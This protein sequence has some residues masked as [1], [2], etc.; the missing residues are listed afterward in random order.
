LPIYTPSAQALLIQLQAATNMSEL[1]VN[2]SSNLLNAVNDGYDTVAALIDPIIGS[3]SSLA[4]YQA[5]EANGTLENQRGILNF[6][7]NFTITDDPG[8]NRTNIDVSSSSLISSVSTPLV[9]T[10]GNLSIPQSS[11]SVDGYLSHTDWTTFNSKGSGTVTSVATDSTLTGGTITSTGTLGLNIA[12]SNTWTATQNFQNILPALGTTYQVGS[13]SLVFTDGYFTNTRTSNVISTSVL[14]L[15][16]YNA[17]TGSYL[18]INNGATTLF[19]FSV[20]TGSTRNLL[21]D[22]TSNTTVITGGQALN[23][24]SDNTFGSSQIDIATAAITAIT[25]AFSANTQTGATINTTAADNTSSTALT[26]KSSNTW[27]TG[28]KYLNIIDNSTSVFFID[29]YGLP[30][31]DGYKIDPRGATSGNSLIYNGTAFIPQNAGSVISS[32]SNLDGTLTVSPTTG[33][34]VASLALGHSNTWSADQTYHN[35]LSATANTFNIGTATNAF[36]DGYFNIVSGNSSGSSLS[37]YDSPTINSS[38]TLSSG[39]I[40]ATSSGLVELQGT[41]TSITS[42]SANNTSTTA[43]SI[44]STATW[45]T[46]NKYLNIINNAT[47]IF[48]IDAYGIP[49]IDGYKIDPRGSTIGETLIYNGTAYIPSAPTGATSVSSDGT[50]TISPTTGAVIAGLK[51]INGSSVL[52]SFGNGTI[53]IDAYGRAT[54]VNSATNIITGTI[55]T[56]QIAVG[57]GTNTISGTSGLTYTA[58]TGLLAASGTSNSAFFIEG[59]GTA[60]VIIEDSGGGNSGLTLTSTGAALQYFNTP[61]SNIILNSSGASVTGVAL[62]VA[63]GLLAPS[64][65][66]STSVSSI[67]TAATSSSAVASIINTSN[68]WSTAGGKLLSVRNNSSEKF[69]V[70]IN[71]LITTDGY[72]LNVSS[73]VVGNALVYNGTSYIPQPVLV[74]QQNVSEQQLTTTSG[75]NILNFTTPNAGNYSVS[76]Y[77]RVVTSIT[78]LGLILNYTSVS[79]AQTQTILTSGIPQA[80]GDYMAAPMYINCTNGS[81]VT[82]IATAGTANNVFMSASAIGII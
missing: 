46:G 61:N 37:L 32:V 47:S 5:V 2:P 20:N 7:S 63:N 62:S 23:L 26:I 74:R 6:S 33:A 81:S 9:V 39:A 41:S 13:P 72:L 30:T 44:G 29:A 68:T 14:N 12:N 22:P 57:T 43:L 73:S 53:T 15:D 55:G 4:F 77:Y 3:I 76:V 10:S 50:L 45:N 79:G 59:S 75:T 82:L 35:I 80:I 28:N 48:S 42:P 78:N 17:T 11:S 25:T 65:T 60:G 70:D 31:I 51:N 69:S 54:T 16:G 71:G 58:S 34:V 49:N 67:S 21:T 1:A 56:A 38:I 52:Y 27:A 8:N 40:A 24:V 36:K 19:S 64:I 18:N 66:S